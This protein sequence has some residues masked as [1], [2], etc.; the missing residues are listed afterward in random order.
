MQ[1]AK[2]QQ[3]ESFVISGEWSGKEHLKVGKQSR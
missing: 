1:H 2:R 3:A